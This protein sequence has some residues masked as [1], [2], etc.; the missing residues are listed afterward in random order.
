[1]Q[2]LV[3]IALAVVLAAPVSVSFPA[4]ADAQVLTGRSGDARR[5]R[6]AARP[7]LSEREQER[8]FQAEEA[9]WE[10]T[11]QIA[12][13]EAAPEPTAEESASLTGLRSRLEE[14]QEVVDRL[15]AKRDRRS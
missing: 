14:E 1:M 10:I 12:T 8:L 11:D 3:V 13:I 4:P 6:R 5:E 15:Q 9:V 2:N 7:A